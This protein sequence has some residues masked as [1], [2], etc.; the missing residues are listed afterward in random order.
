MPD[1]PSEDVGGLQVGDTLRLLRAR[2]DLL[3][4]KLL[5]SPIG[6]LRHA[7]LGPIERST[8]SVYLFGTLPRFNSTLAANRTTP[9][10]PSPR[11]FER[12]LARR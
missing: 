3:Y 11:L 8:R 5:A 10:T 9:P 2:L 7:E 6:G 1:A 12:C 4:R